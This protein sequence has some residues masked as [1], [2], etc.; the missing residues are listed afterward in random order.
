MEYYINHRFK[1]VV[2]LPFVGLHP[3]IDFVC[4]PD[5]D[6]ERI[7]TTADG[8]RCNVVNWSCKNI[9]EIEDKIR[10]LYNI[11]VITFLKKWYSVD[12]AMQSL[13]MFV[14]ELKKI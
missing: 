14:L 1:D 6:T 12:N 10:E 13:Y 7:V 2:I 11:D 5:N 9:L 4:Q 3:N 8:V